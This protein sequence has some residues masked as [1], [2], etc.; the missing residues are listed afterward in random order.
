M[1]EEV[2]FECARCGRCCEQRLILL[3]TEDVF[4]M[5][6]NLHLTVPEF[7]EKYNVVFARAGDN[8]KTP[9]LFLQITGDRCPFFT[10]G[11]SIHAFKPL[12]CRQFP[13][14]KPGQTAAEMKAYINKHAISEG[15]KSC[16]VFSLPDEA[17]LA[18][19]REAMI[20]SV[21]YDSAETIYYSNLKRTDM[22]FILNLLK[23]VNRD[24]LRAI[25]DDYLF[26][27][28]VESGLIFEQA[29]FEI[30]AMCQVIDWQCTPYIVVNDGAAF[31]PGQIMVFVTPQDARDIFEAST[32]GQVEAV[33]SQANP[34]IADPSV[35]FIS[36]AIRMK[37]ARGMMLAFMGKK[38]ELQG[39]TS[40]GKAMLGFYPSDGSM[41]QIAAMSIFVDP[42]VIK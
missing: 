33:F 18:V 32:G 41:D 7:M 8:N 38:D 28:S 25:V 36:V 17:V 14:V 4:R 31:E 1:G 24:Q 19:D 22:K 12:M 3:N 15:V 42:A 40:D 26:N 9:R 16:K 34:S 10:D 30:Q 2:T 5:A 27:G 29:M 13:A 6:E 20:T 39:V 23:A 35:V 37:G 21:I 11:C